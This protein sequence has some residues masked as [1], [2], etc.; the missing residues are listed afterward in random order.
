MQPKAAKLWPAINQFLSLNLI[1]DNLYISF[2]P[3][4]KQAKR[5]K[6]ITATIKTPN[7][8]NM[9]DEFLKT[10]VANALLAYQPI[11]KTAN[12]LKTIQNVEIKDR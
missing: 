12:E 5:T 6:K 7:C 10:Q 9:I 1:Q 4:R 2:E 11:K 3:K 8:R